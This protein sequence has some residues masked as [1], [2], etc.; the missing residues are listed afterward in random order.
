MLHVLVNLHYTIT[1]SDRILCYVIAE[2]P[3]YI[4]PHHVMLHC[5]MLWYMIFHQNVIVYPALGTIFY[6][7]FYF[8]TVPV[9]S[10]QYT[11]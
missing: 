11:S 10:M 7:L 9:F 2:T 4:V 5:I 1:H 6:S 8:L 3:H